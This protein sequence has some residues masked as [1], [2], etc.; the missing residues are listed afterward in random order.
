LRKADCKV[1]VETSISSKK[2]RRMWGLDLDSWNKIVWAL[3]VIAGIAAVLVAC[4][5]WV[6]YNLQKKEALDAKESPEK[7]KQDAGAKIAEANAIAATATKEAAAIRER[8]ALTEERLLSERR[9]T[10]SERWRLE[11]VERATLPRSLYVNWPAL[12]AELKAGKFHPINLALVG[13]SMEASSFALDLTRA[14]QQ[15][16]VLGRYIDLSSIPPEADGKA[17][18]S[19]GVT[20]IF[21]DSDGDRLGQMLWQ[22][23]QIGGGGFSATVLPA[24]WASIPTHAN[25]LVVEDNNWAVSPGNGQPGEGIDEHGEPVPAPQ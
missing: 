13:G 7:Y 1:A 24:A 12:V 20:I 16:A 21:G 19:S 14:L 6:S 2:V 3:G 4:S 10:A 8:A 9:L 5:G 15:A 17:Q 18:S 11:R 22:K 23:F 25:C